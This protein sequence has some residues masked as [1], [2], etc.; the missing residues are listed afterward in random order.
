MQR[1]KDCTEKAPNWIFR[2]HPKAPESL[3]ERQQK[4][5]KRC[6]ERSPGHSV[7]QA[8]QGRSACELSSVTACARPVD[9]PAMKIQGRWWICNITASH[10]VI[11][12]GWL[13]GGESKRFLGFV[14]VLVWFKI[15][16]LVG[17]PERGPGPKPGS[18]RAIKTGFMGKGEKDISK[19]D[20]K[21][22]EGWVRG[23]RKNWEGECVLTRVNTVWF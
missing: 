14:V 7:P 11:S 12:I 2:P 19:F 21:W 15:Q 6:G 22:Q 13:L 9:N 23:K 20:G 10:R 18:N 16:P 3:Q 4:D 1:A 8:Q 17:W 5:C